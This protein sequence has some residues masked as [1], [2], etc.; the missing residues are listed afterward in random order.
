MTISMSVMITQLMLAMTFP[1]GESCPPFMETATP[2]KMAA[3]MQGSILERLK[4]FGKSS[5]V[6]VLTSISPAEIGFASS[7]PCME[8]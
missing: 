3:I 2:V 7:T 6:S 8:T 5:T 1:R 4:I